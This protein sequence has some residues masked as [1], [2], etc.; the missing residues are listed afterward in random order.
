MKNF[1]IF[2]QVQIKAYNFLWLF[3][4]TFVL[5]YLPLNSAKSMAKLSFSS[6]VT[7]L[8]LCIPRLNQISYP[9]V[10]VFVE[11]ILVF[12]SNCLAVRV[13]QNQLRDQT[14]L[15]LSELKLLQHHCCWRM[16]MIWSGKNCKK[17]K[18]AYPRKVFSIWSFP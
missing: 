3:L 8:Y 14:L 9:G 1:D 18:V 11:P 13:G 17:L 16:R 15:A 10:L 5:A 7:L 6:E 2:Y 12:C 4:Q